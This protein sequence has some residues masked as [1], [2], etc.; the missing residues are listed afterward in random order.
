MY[1]DP[2]KYTNVEV[3]EEHFTKKGDKVLAK[4]NL[5]LVFKGGDEVFIEDVFKNKVTTG[6]LDVG[7]TV[8]KDSAEFEPQGQ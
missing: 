5:S 8:I 1:S 2:E 7:L 4:A 6:E 3:S